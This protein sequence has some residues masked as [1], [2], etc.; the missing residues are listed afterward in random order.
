M[1]FAA[2]ALGRGF[3]SILCLILSLD[4]AECNA[5]SYQGINYGMHAAFLIMGSLLE[6]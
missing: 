1:E 6:M 2:V 5:E 4:D 3:S